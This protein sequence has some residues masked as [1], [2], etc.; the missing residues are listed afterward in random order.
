MGSYSQ[1]GVLKKHSHGGLS[2]HAWSHRIRSQICSRFRTRSRPQSYPLRRP[3]LDTRPH[4]LFHPLKHPR[5]H[6][7]F[8]PLRR[9]RFHPLQHPRMRT[10]LRTL[11][12]TRFPGQDARCI[13]KTSFAHPPD[14]SGLRPET[15]RLA[16]ESPLGKM[17][18][19]ISKEAI[20]GPDAVLPN[21]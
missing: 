4:P 12:T 9:P 1:S 2:D 7:L 10:R 11:K 15:W 18:L 20:H 5:M 17:A 13:Y 6:T 3:R 14:S 8:H 16:L 21:F 19:S